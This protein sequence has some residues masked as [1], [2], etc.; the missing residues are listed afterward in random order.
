MQVVCQYLL[1]L[2][3]RKINSEDIDFHSPKMTPLSA[4]Q[5]AQL[6]DYHYITKQQNMSFAILNIFVEFLSNQLVKFTQSQFFTVESL[7]AMMGKNNPIRGNLL[8]VLLQVSADFAHRAASVSAI[9]VSLFIFVT[10][11][12]K[13]EEANRKAATAVRLPTF[14]PD[15]PLS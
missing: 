13:A 7:K 3:Q 5:C 2:S 11:S 6:L 14:C 10:A 1:A 15:L 8:T 4:P 9:Q 12:K